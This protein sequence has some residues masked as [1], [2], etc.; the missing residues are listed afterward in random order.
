VKPLI[1]EASADRWHRRLAH[2]STRVMKKTA[3]MI[4]GVKINEDLL[5]TEEEGE[6]C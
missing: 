6:L 3:E 4:D 1:L 5:E 2:V